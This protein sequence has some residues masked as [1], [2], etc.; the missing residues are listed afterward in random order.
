MFGGH[1]PAVAN[2]YEKIDEYISHRRE[3]EEMILIA[4]RD[5]FSTP[6]EIVARVYTDVPPKAHVMAER[7]VVAHLKKLEAD[8]LVTQT[9]DGTYQARANN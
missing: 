3:R 2:P 5:G 9:A 7:A 4:L 1:G 6:K 8:E